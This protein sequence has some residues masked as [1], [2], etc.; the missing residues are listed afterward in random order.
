MV[1]IIYGGAEESAPQFQIQS[2][3][4]TLV[5]LRTLNIYDWLRDRKMSG[6]G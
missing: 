2:I 3:M 5:N 4:V 6:H 1:I